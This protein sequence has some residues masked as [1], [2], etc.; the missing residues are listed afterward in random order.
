M[1]GLTRAKAMSGAALLATVIFA[2]ALAT[3][4]I[5]PLATSACLFAALALARL[6]M[7]LAAL[8]ALQA[9]LAA[10]GVMLLAATSIARK[11]TMIILCGVIAGI[12]TSVAVMLIVAVASG[13]MAVFASS[14]ALLM[15]ALLARAL[16]MRSVLTRTLVLAGPGIVRVMLGAT[17]S[18]A[19]AAFRIFAIA[20]R[21]LMRIRF[22][23]LIV[24]AALAR[25]LRA[26][27]LAAP[28]SA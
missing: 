22:V 6:A 20:S 9:L 13:A 17:C 8:L 5:G 16:R 12:L 19:A 2:F 25:T 27:M 15:L 7:A 18:L 3:L 28:S 1:T 26:L 24:T 10:S 4:V 23:L 21:V 11:R 14:N